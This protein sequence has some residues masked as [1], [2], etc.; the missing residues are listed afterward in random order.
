MVKAQLFEIQGSPAPLLVGQTLIQ[1]AVA[2]SQLHS[3]KV[4]HFDLKLANVL[5]KSSGGRLV[6]KVGDIGLHKRVPAGEDHIVCTRGRGTLFYIAPEMR[7]LI[8]ELC[9]TL[10]QSS[11]KATEKVDVFSICRLGVELM[12]GRLLSAVEDIGQAEAQCAT[13][14]TVGMLHAATVCLRAS[15]VTLHRPCFCTMLDVARY[16]PAKLFQAYVCGCWL[17]ITLDQQARRQCWAPCVHVARSWLRYG[18]N[19][20]ARA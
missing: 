2:V 6:I 14:D 8:S 11:C 13:S 5:L 3:A 15:R 9:P 4:F 1:I 17:A 10:A 16:W 7:R 20:L 19:A 12:S 18:S